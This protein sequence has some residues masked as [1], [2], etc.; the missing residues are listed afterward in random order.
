[1]NIPAK[2]KSRVNEK[3]KHYQKIV[4]TLNEK[5]VDESTTVRCITK[6]LETIM[7]YDP[8]MDI[9]SEFAIKKTFNNSYCDLAIKG[10]NGKVRILLE[11]K[12][13]TTELNDKHLKQA[14]D[15]GADTGVKWVILTNLK[16]WKLYKLTD[17]RPIDREFIFEFNF[18][19]L[20]SK[21]DKDLAYLFKISKEGEEGDL[22][23]GYY[24]QK[25][26]KNKYMIGAFLSSEDVYALIRKN[27]RKLYDDVKISVEEIEHIIKNEIILKEILN[28]DEA[29]QTKKEIIKAQKKLEKK[30]GK[31][32]KTKDDTVRK[33]EVAPN[34]EAIDDL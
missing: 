34:V 29:L 4:Q 16:T 21:S 27:I 18:M 22:L 11:A 5:Q 31:N 15:Y 3:L 33:T 17:T 23:A 25:Q 8:Y 32:K 20:N 10:K 30:E 12:S 26:I 28:S 9:T 14:L 24:A 1:M 2:F 7:G 19:E 13:I 6:I